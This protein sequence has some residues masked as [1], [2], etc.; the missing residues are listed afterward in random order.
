MAKM[1]EV[2]TV[3]RSL[4]LIITLLAAGIPASAQMHAPATSGAMYPPELTR[5]ERPKGR[6][7]RLRDQ[8]RSTGLELG[9]V[10]LVPR[11]TQRTAKALRANLHKRPG[12]RLSLRSSRTRAPRCTPQ[13]ASS[14]LPSLSNAQLDRLS[15]RRSPCI[16]ASPLHTSLKS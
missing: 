2:S 13:L 3:L 7:V 4:A 6:A 8:G 16:I 14:R 11:R 1:M 12:P 5:M 15:I 9:R 10:L